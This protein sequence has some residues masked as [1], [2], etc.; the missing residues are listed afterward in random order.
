[1]T[2]GSGTGPDAG[3]DDRVRRHGAAGGQ[4]GVGQ[5]RH[6][7]LRGDDGRGDLGGRA[8]GSGAAATRTEGGRRRL[9]LHLHG[10]G[11]GHRLW[12]RFGGGPRAG[13]GLVALAGLRHA[14]LI[15][16]TVAGGP[17]CAAAAGVGGGIV[18][19]LVSGL[20][21]AE[22]AG[23]ELADALAGI[24]GGDLDGA[25]RALKLGQRLLIARQRLSVGGD[26]NGLLVGEHAHELVV[27]HARP[28]ADAAGVQM[29]EI[30]AGIEADAAALH[31]QAHHAD[32]GQ[33]HSRHVEV[34]GLAAHVLALFSH[35]LRAGAQH[36][37]GG[38]RAIAAQHRD[39]F[40]GTHLPID[41][42]HEIKQFRVH[43]RGLGMAP[44]A[45]EPVEL[46]QGLRIVAALALECEDTALARIVVEH[47]E[48][49]RIAIGHRILQGGGGK[50]NEGENRQSGL[51]P[52][53]AAHTKGGGAGKA[54]DAR[55]NGQCREPEAQVYLCRALIGRAA[56]SSTESCRV[57][58]RAC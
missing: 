18:L 9:L 6:D 2:V 47:G 26:V 53:A 49:A 13:D 22:Q 12:R 45:Q 31:A 36:G 35:A 32:G 4:R 5:R 46:L 44:V 52:A 19:H 34:H 30:V 39:A 1:M 42:P 41:L 57:R 25:L 33:F 27:G 21:E 48:R 28:V 24:A 38:R 17:A 8:D 20:L 51:C 56:R 43:V 16:R 7:G 3:G 40:L 55:K 58:L 37:I 11:E 23:E 50:E 15:G 29:D 14:S 54:E 10:P